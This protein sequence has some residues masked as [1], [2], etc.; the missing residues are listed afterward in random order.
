MAGKIKKEVFVMRGI[1]GSRK[2]TSSTYGQEMDRSKKTL[3]KVLKENNEQQMMYVL[4]VAALKAKGEDLSITTLKRLFNKARLKKEVVLKKM[5]PVTFY[6]NSL[7]PE[8]AQ[9]FIEKF[10]RS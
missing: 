6:L 10:E 2:N 1:L 5:R 9:R 3:E 8:E 7:M 4:S